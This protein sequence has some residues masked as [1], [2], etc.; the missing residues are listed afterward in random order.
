MLGLGV[1]KRMYDQ[2]STEVRGSRFFDE[3]VLFVNQEIAHLVDK[4][5]LKKCEKAVT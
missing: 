5:I 1:T 3:L 2:L 4:S